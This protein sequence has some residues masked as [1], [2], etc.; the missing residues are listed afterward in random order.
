MSRKTSPVSGPSRRPRRSPGARPTQQRRRKERVTP[1]A[2]E[3]LPQD[4]HTTREK[5]RSYIKVA[6]LPNAIVLAFVIAAAFGGLLLTSTTLSALP[7][8]IAQLWLTLNAAPVSGRGV[9]ISLMPLLP[10]FLVGYGTYRRVRTSPAVRGGLKDMGL[11]AIWIVGIPVLLTLTAIVMLVDA[12]TVFDVGVPNVAI[13][14]LRTAGIYIVAFL[15]GLRQPLWEATS[16]R[17]GLEE[18]LYQQVGRAVRL[19]VWFMVAGGGVTLVSLGIHHQQIAELS[20]NY[21]PLGNLGVW[22]L[23]LL[24]LPNAALSGWAL[25]MGSEFAMGVGSVSL[26]GSTLPPLPPVPLMAALPLSVSPY[27]LALLVIP[28]VIMTI[29]VIRKVPTAVESLYLTV[30]TMVVATCAFF[31][32]GGTAG[33]YEYVGPTILLSIGLAVA[34]VAVASFMT[35]GVATVVSR[36]GAARNDQEEQ[37]FANDEDTVDDTEEEISDRE[38]VEE[39]QQEHGGSFAEQEQH[40]EEDFLADEFQPVGDS[41]LA[42]EDPIAEGDAN[43]GEPDEPALGG[44]SAEGQ[45]YLDAE[46]DI[47][48]YLLDAGWDDQLDDEEESDHMIAE[49]NP[50]GYDPN[51]T[52]VPGD[53]NVDIPVIGEPAAADPLGQPE[54]PD[55]SRTERS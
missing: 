44:D 12:A 26:Y 49:G 2:Q 18:T 36:L 35:T 7:A 30:A 1:G 34:W 52:G 43:A 48:D 28:A 4:H 3:Q 50:R 37:P 17:W 13:A 6:L 25:L 9:D 32:A 54:P 55:S 5:M 8:T 19:C 16:A 22:L 27:A 21:S 24:Y 20:S 41:Q 10:A 15:F 39:D 42:E 45:D 40:E 53:T 33:I 11:Q 38:F 47:E 46:A 29:V 14:L 23:S 31:Y 51:T